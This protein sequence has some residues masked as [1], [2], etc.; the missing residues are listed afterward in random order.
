MSCSLSP[1]TV[2]FTH[3]TLT[4]SAEPPFIQLYRACSLLSVL[5]NFTYESNHL[6]RTKHIYAILCI[7][8]LC[9][10]LA[11]N[12]MKKLTVFLYSIHTL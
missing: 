12:Y 4:W 8:G 7:T 2:A 3:F 5:P 10:E 1:I 9:V 11:I 6:V